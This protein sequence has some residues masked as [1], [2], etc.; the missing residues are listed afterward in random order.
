MAGE[1]RGLLAGGPSAA[2]RGPG[3]P[4]AAR[5][6]WRPDG[7]SEGSRGAVA[8]AAAA[9][10]GGGRAQPCGARGGEALFPEVPGGPACGRNSSSGDWLG[11]V[12]NPVSSSRPWRDWKFIV[13][14]YL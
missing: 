7:R 1:G 14:A 9:G 10:G 11:P 12:F 3:R 8:D 6:R 2:R 5:G 13:G 4:G